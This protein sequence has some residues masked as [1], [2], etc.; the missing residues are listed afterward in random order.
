MKNPGKLL[1]KLS[2]AAFVLVATFCTAV[3]AQN[4]SEASYIDLGNGVTLNSVVVSNAGTQQDPV[5]VFLTL[6]GVTGN[7]TSANRRTV[8]ARGVPTS[9]NTP[10]GNTAA[11]TVLAAYGVLA[12]T[13]T[14]NYASYVA[15]ALDQVSVAFQEGNPDH[16][17]VLGSVFNGDMESS[18]PS[19]SDIAIAKV[20]DVASPSFF[21]EVLGGSN[22]L[23]SQFS[24]LNPLAPA[25]SAACS[26]IAAQLDIDSNGNL[27]VY[28]FQGNGAPFPNVTVIISVSLATGTPVQYQAVSEANGEAPFNVP[29][30][31]VTPTAQTNITS[32]TLQYPNAGTVS[33]CTIPLQGNSCSTSTDLAAAVRS[34]NARELSARLK[35]EK[36]LGSQPGTS[37]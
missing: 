3:Q 14:P 10:A 33:V 17:F 28:V 11:T 27:L 4:V 9:S 30:N 6:T 34:G 16:P 20:A 36:D 2:M 23:L 1:L 31:T 15:A 35:K 29:G 22:S 7:G 13:V 18:E 37:F 21:R 25:P 5:E 32:I 24:L 12:G 26:S 19:L 8:V